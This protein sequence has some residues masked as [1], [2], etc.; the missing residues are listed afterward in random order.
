MGIVFAIAWIVGNVFYDSFPI[1]L[2]L[3]FPSFFISWYLMEK[4]YREKRKRRLTEEFLKALSVLNDYLKSGHSILNGIRE[5]TRELRLLYGE[6]SDIV[7][8]WNELCHKT[9]AGSTPEE[10]F[11]DLSE[12]TDISEIREFA[13]VFQ[14]VNRRGGQLNEVLDITI[15]DLNEKFNVDSQ[16]Q[17][18]IAS[19]KLEQKIMS[20]MPVAILLYVKLTSPDLLQSLYVGAFGRIFMT[21][22]LLIYIGAVIWGMRI[23]RIRM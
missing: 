11:R 17:T 14:I 22:S 19:K 8:E 10:C 16:I 13:D 23:I 4:N 6:N 18:M 20:A 3:F 7:R 15:E 9:S 21:I 12:R 5:S 1:G 2:F